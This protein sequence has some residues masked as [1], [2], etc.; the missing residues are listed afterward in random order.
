[1]A[2]LRRAVESEQDAFGAIVEQLHEEM[3]QVL[4]IPFS[5]LL[6]GFPPFV[7]SVSRAQ[8]KDVELVMDGGAIEVDRR[9]S[10]ASKIP[11]CI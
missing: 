3:K 5:A 9:V 11:S 4:M 8:G 7:R 10:K 6:I 2:A 1:V